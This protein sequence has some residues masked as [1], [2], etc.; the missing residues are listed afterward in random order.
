M[1]DSIF[2]RA[3]SAPSPC[4]TD[5]ALAAYI[6]GGLGP[7]E[8]RQVA[9]HLADCEDCFDLYS[10][11]A[12]F[13]VDSSPAALAGKG[14]VRFP[15]L[16]E[17]RRQVVQWGS[18]AALLIVGVGGGGAWFGLLEPPP[19]LV[20]DDV[21]ATLAGKPELTTKFWVGPTTRGP[22]GEGQD[23]AIR[24]ASFQM[25]VQ[26]VNLLLSLRANDAEGTRG[27]ILPRIFGLL[28][29]QVAVTPV[30]ESYQGLAKSLEQRAP[31]EVAGAAAQIGRESREYF[32]ESY[33]DLGQWVEAGRL[34]SFAKDPHFFQQG[35][36]R[37]FLRHIIWN[38]KLKKSDDK[39][40]AATLATL[41]Q[42][43]DV[44]PSG[45][46]Q[47]SNYAKLRPLFNKILEAH[48]PDT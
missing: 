6:D 17:R 2:I 22:G 29:S 43:S 30:I 20:A 33:F 27:S 37:S 10:E 46:L 14:V 42:I 48:Y 1:R 16:A 5:E 8:S 7:A 13:L 21:T 15:T 47:P 36:N 32:D 34:A 9:E 3:R 44:L 24:E 18:I 35:A 31:R 23:K 40:D 39:L 11:T 4:P 28:N 19:P 38:D 41:Q 12:R 26:T 25:G 45:D